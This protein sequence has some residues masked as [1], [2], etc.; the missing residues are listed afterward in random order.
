MHLFIPRCLKD[1]VFRWWK[2]KVLRRA[3]DHLNRSSLME[4]GGENAIYF[5]PEKY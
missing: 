4:V 3:G 1:L 2:L 5:D